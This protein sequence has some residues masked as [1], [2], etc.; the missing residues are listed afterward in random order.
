MLRHTRALLCI[1]H[2][3][4]GSPVLPFPQIALAGIPTLRPF[5]AASALRPELE[6]SY[7]GH[8]QGAAR[9]SQD[10]PR[11]DRICCNISKS[12]PAV[13]LPLLIAASHSVSMVT[14]VF[15]MYCST[16][17][18]MAADHLS[19]QGDRS[20]FACGLLA[21][22]EALK[23]SMVRPL[24]PTRAQSDL[25][26]SGGQGRWRRPAKKTSGGPDSRRTPF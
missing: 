20:L 2:L 21:R 8:R 23:N 15:S 18:E 11:H 24:A 3:V 16:R 13:G 17:C 10:L 19:W 22:R 25:P 12:A 14:Y 5:S 6:P 4:T 26:T 7:R 9:N 1:L